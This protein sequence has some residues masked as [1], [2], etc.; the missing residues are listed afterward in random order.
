MITAPIIT[1]Q[2]MTDVIAIMTYSEGCVPI[3]CD[4]VNAVP[5][6]DI[7]VR[8]GSPCSVDVDFIVDDEGMEYGNIVPFARLRA[9]NSSDTVISSFESVVDAMMIEYVGDGED[10]A[11]VDD[12]VEIAGCDDDDDVVVHDVDIADGDELICGGGDDVFV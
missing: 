7:E 2:D 8:K 10:I 6:E 9:V 1:V 5:V 11:S 4:S 3:S 12:D